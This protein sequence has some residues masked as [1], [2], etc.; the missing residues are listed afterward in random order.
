MKKIGWIGT[1]IMGIS[2]ATHLRNAGHELTVYSRTKQKAQSL[3]DL[4]ATWA[5]TPREV[6]EN[7]DIVFSIVGFPKDVE[8][9]ILGEN[10]V[11]Q[12]LKPGGIVCDMTTSCPTLAQR[13]SREAMTKGCYGVD[14][15]VTGGD[16]GAKNATLSIF[17][18]AF[19]DTFTDILPCLEKMGKTVVHCGEAGMGQKAKLANQIAVAGVMFSVCESLLFAKECGLDV[20]QWRQTV[21]AGAAGSTAMNVLGKRIVDNDFAPGFFIEHFC[22]DLRLC[23]EQCRQMGLT[24]PGLTLAEQAYNILSE[25]GYAKDGTQVL[26][27]G[28]AHLSNKK[29]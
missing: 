13:I 6:A 17:V 3:L 4:G 2:M 26:I 20:E 25:N 24:L 10:G 22:K 14:A 19:S 23:I 28:L 8:E 18:G 1:G 5:N 9:V 11:L 27:K 15:P 29:W 21:V 12:G 16:V 7:S